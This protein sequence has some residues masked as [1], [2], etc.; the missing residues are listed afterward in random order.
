MLN[1]SLSWLLSAGRYLSCALPCFLFLA[2]DWKDRP[3][4]T[5]ALGAGMFLLQLVL[6]L[7]YLS[8]GQ[9]M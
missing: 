4:A 8:W 7:R 2:E 5:V 3:R 1:Y 9:V 6:L